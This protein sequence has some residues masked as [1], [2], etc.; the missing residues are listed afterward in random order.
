MKENAYYFLGSNPTNRLLA[1]LLATV[2]TTLASMPFDTLRV[3]LYTMRQLPN[4]VWPYEGT[5]DCLTKIIKYESNTKNHGNLQSLYAGAYS[6]FARYFLIFY[7]SQYMIDWYVRGNYVEE[8][9]SPSSY[10]SPSSIAFNAYEP[11]TLA[12]HKGFVNTVVEDSEDTIGLA[13]D[14]KPLKVV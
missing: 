8:L 9:W 2:V 5:L 7:A 6:Y 11:F 13:P 1:T 10:V 12:Y 14:R 3:R 4:G